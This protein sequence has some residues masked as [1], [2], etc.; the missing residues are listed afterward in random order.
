M[1]TLAD[2][3]G[4]F[5]KAFRDAALAAINDPAV[6]VCLGHPGRKMP[7]DVFSVGDTTIESQA[8]GF[9]PVR[10]R[11]VTIT[12]EVIVSVYREGGPA[13]EEVASD[14]AFELLSRVADYLHGDGSDAGNGQTSV[15][16]TVLYCFLT[17]AGPAGGSRDAQLLA[18]GRL[19]EIP[20]TFTAFVQI[21]SY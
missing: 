11:D 19:I 10:P 20:A 15:G 1:T 8:A 17:H 13:Q 14:R 5:R 7:D 12:Q 6:L 2:V 3:A 18:K 16:M 9:S 21:R 4:P